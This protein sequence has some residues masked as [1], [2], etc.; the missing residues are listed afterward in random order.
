MQSSQSGAMADAARLFNAAV[1]HYLARRMQDAERDC[2]RALELSPR[3]ADA[4]QLLGVLHAERGDLRRA[5]GLF[6]QSIE[7]NP[8]SAPAQ[9]ALAM[10]LHKLGQV[11]EAEAAFRRAID[12]R[13]DLVDAQLGL[14]RALMDQGRTSEADACF[15]RALVLNPNLIRPHNELGTSVHSYGLYVSHRPD[16]DVTNHH[17]EFKTLLP[18]WT[19]ANAENN[20]GDLARLYT[21]MLNIKQVI[22]DGVPGDMAEV[23]VYRGNSA[24]VLA[25]YARSS[26]R[27]LFLFDTFDGFDKRDLTGVDRRVSADFSTTSLQLVRQVV[28]EANVSFVEGYFP[29]SIPDGFSERTFAVVH[30]DCDLYSPMKAGLEFFYPRLAPGGLLLLHDYSSGCFPGAKQAVDEFAKAIPEN[31][32]LQRDKSGTAIIRKFSASG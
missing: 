32:V 18:K 30:L 23:G 25:Y 21:L 17:P 29:Q 1:E 16:S 3:H 8:Q 2:R 11:S 4:L 26:A 10:A 13:P 28:G 12:L 14:G 31:I 5:V 22:A 20:S 27:Q 24:A 19:Y 6:N 9:M 7:T 15:R